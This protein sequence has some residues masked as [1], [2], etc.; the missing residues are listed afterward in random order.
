MRMQ[1]SSGL[2]SSVQRTS[3]GA[4]PLPPATHTHTHTHTPRLL[5]LCQAWLLY[6]LTEA[7]DVGKV[8]H[9]APQ[10]RRGRGPMGGTFTRIASL[11]RMAASAGSQLVLSR[12]KHKQQAGAQL[13]PSYYG[14]PKP[15]PGTYNSGKFEGTW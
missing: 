11:T 9:E 12:V 6:S 15:Q 14:P 8:E 13:D 5:C 1:D 7:H 10:Q 2:S 4:V 3:P